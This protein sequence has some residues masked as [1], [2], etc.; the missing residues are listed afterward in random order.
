M[1]HRLAIEHNED[2][3]Y[4]VLLPSAITLYA[5]DNPDKAQAFIDGWDECVYRMGGRDAR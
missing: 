3:Y 1:I 5:T 2:G 4:V